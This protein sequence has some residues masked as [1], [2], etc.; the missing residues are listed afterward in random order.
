M[1][2]DGVVAVM[3][4]SALFWLPVVRSFRDVTLATITHFLDCKLLGAG[5]VL[6][7]GM[8]IM[9]SGCYCK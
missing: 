5:T 4:R 1:L 9:A 6:D 3:A 2:L 7:N 8:L